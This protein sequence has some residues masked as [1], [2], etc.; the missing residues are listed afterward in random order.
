MAHHFKFYG[1]G[2][3][4]IL[5]LAVMLRTANIDIQKVFEYLSAVELEKFGKT[6]LTVCHNFF[7]EGYDYAID[8][9]NESCRQIFRQSRQILQIKSAAKRL[10][11]IT[12]YKLC[13][14][15]KQNTVF[16]IVINRPVFLN[17]VKTVRY[18]LL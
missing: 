15:L 12:A 6:V 9:K 11:I 18:K 16:D 2:I 5:D 13:V 4:L 14:H 3:K 17:T 10:G 1:A 7:G 8:T